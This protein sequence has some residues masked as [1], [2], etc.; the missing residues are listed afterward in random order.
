MGD[1]VE[2][3][4]EQIFPPWAIAQGGTVTP[5][6]PNGAALAG[7]GVV[8]VSWG[9]TRAGLSSTARRCPALASVLA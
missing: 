9:D 5:H 2:K 1:K 6:T 8:G 4:Y 7:G 3:L